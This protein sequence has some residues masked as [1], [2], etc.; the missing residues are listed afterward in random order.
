MTET[1]SS[2]FDS[3]IPRAPDG[4]I[5]DQS[6][7]QPTTSTPTQTNP[8]SP[9]TSNSNPPVDPNAPKPAVSPTAPAVPERYEFKAPE[10]QTL[11]PAVVDR[12]TPIFRELGL[13]NAAAQRLVDFYTGEMKSHADTAKAA[14]ISMGK[15]WSDQT[16]ADPKL[17]PHIDTIKADVGRALD[18]LESKDPGLKAEFQSAMD[19]TMVGNHPAFIR[20]FWAFAKSVAPGTHVPGGGP[21]PMGQS[22]TGT[23]A[24]K[25]A[26]A[27]MYPH[28]VSKAG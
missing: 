13:D 9:S 26:A 12:A 6:S 21:S 27:A 18:L 10:G 15:T 14:I 16:M 7:T 25:S 4:T 11:D 2:A 19:Q 17:G 22:P 1:T 20:A 3:Q 23:I 5:L 24:P 8:D 28:L